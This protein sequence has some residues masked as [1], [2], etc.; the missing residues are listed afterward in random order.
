MST[1]KHP[2]HRAIERALQ[3]AKRRLPELP[4]ERMLAARLMTHAQRQSQQLS[5][6]VLRKHA[7]NYGSY[8]VLMVL[9]GA[10]PTGIGATELAQATGERQAN[11][12]RICDELHARKLIAREPA[13]DDR[14]RVMLRLTRAGEKLA[15]L[16]QPEIW[17]AV[18][19]LY[20][21]FTLA[22][23]RQL[24]VLLGKQLMTG[25]GGTP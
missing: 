16:V 11:L 2:R 23:L 20:A 1:D 8:S 9:Y 18:D 7:L 19:R 21:G 6:A 4:Y 3:G 12:T 13:S 17:R 10:D 25:T 5:N 22:E 14:R 24:Q 15:E